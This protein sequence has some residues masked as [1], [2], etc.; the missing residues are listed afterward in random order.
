MSSGWL[1][2][3]FSWGAI[4]VSVRPGSPRPWRRNITTCSSSAPGSPESGPPSTCI[5]DARVNA[6]S[7][8]RLARPWAAPGISS[9]IP[10]SAPTATCTRWDTASNPGARRSRS[11]TG[12]RSCATSRRRP[13]STGSTST[14]ATA[15]APPVPPG[16]PR[17]PPGRSRRSRP[18]PARPCASHATSCSCAPGTT[19]TSRA[20][21]RSSPARN[22]SAG[23]SSTRR[24]GP[25]TWPTRGN[26][27]W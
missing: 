20:T 17:M 2:R 25:R 24:S 22:V 13:P 12:R 6:T 4:R 27:W 16:P 10:A 5:R 19:A 8:W 15:T 3:S 23:R 21:R 1:A 11:R 14:S 9:A 7:S 26:V 18:R